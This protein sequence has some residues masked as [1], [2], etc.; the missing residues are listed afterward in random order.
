[1]IERF[2]RMQE[3]DLDAEKLAHCR[4]WTGRWCLFFVVNGATAATLAIA[5]PLWWWTVYTGGI[6][7]ALMGLMFALEWMGRPRSPRAVR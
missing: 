4:R 6:A 3:P 7:Y 2:A 5:A 1:M